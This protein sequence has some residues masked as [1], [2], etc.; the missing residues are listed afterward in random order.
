MLAI[1]DPKGKEDN[2][3]IKK[4]GWG[5]GLVGRVLCNHGNMSSDS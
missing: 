1:E 4:E 5:D 3:E 2:N